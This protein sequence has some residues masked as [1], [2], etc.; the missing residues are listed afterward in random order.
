MSGTQQ[1]RDLAEPLPE[2]EITATVRRLELL[3]S[4]EEPPVD[5]ERLARIDAARQAVPPA[6]RTKEICGWQHEIRTACAL[7]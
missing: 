5:P 1:L 4:R 3:T 6:S 2:P 7:P